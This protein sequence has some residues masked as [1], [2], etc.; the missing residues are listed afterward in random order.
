MDALDFSIFRLASLICGMLIAV[1]GMNGMR[2][3]SAVVGRLAKAEI[4]D[5]VSG[6][7]AFS[8][9]AAIGVTVRS[10]FSYTTETI[11]QAG[12][13]DLKIVS[14]P[15]GVNA[16]TRPSRLFRSIPQFVIRT[17]RTM[18]RAYAM[19]EPLKIFLALGAVMIVAGAAPIVRF[20]IAY[21][22]GDGAGMIQSLILG[23][24]LILMGGVCVMFALIADLIAYNR[25]LQ[26]LTL[27]SVR[28]MEYGRREAADGD[29]ETR[30]ISE[31]VAGLRAA[32]E[33]KIAESR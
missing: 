4:A 20:L 3:G 9:E 29:P 25:R 27:E 16:V 2:R 26:E 17:G 18:V 8:R 15:V 24:V 28:R 13:K 11:I 22:S 5:A 30:C 6:F 14:V 31:D 12:R 1:E 21:F 7:R 23:A 33:K 10:T 19:Y 32:L